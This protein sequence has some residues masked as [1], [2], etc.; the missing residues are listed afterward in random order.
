MEHI[1][2]FMRSGKELNSWK[3]KVDSLQEEQEGV[4]IAEHQVHT[5]NVDSFKW[6]PNVKMYL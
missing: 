5:G 1:V 2:A 3:A 4:S 6:N